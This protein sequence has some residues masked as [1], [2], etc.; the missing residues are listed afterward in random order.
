M[1]DRNKDLFRGSLE[2]EDFFVQFMRRRN[3]S[4]AE[5]IPLS[6]QTSWPIV[7]VAPRKTPSLPVFEG[8]KPALPAQKPLADSTAVNAVPCT[9]VCAACGASAN[10]Q[11]L[12]PLLRI[13]LNPHRFNPHSVQS[14]TPTA[15][16]AGRLEGSMNAAHGTMLSL[17]IAMGSWACSAQKTTIPF[18]QIERDAQLTATL[19]APGSEISS[20]LYPAVVSSGLSGGAGFE[21]VSPIRAPR[22]LSSNYYL[23]NGV[24]LG[25]AVFDV[26]MTQHCIATHQCR[27]G[28]PL[29]PSSQAGALSMNLALVSYSSFISYRLK[30]HH[31]RVWW[32]SPTISIVAHG[33]GVASGLAH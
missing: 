20:S 29:M 5:A 28:N 16:N 30:K 18:A 25:M 8:Q 13:D 27:E 31:S 32:I 4:A 1:L 24:D 19:S 12:M 6:A 7:R 21:R 9:G 23:L 22:I 15:E 14:I 33:A 3:T 2:D 10:L 11:A 26:E 17:A